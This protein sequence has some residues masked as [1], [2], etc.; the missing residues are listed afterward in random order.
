MS[1][2]EVM[3]ILTTISAGLVCILLIPAAINELRD[4]NGK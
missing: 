1:A 3:I 4:R 2:V